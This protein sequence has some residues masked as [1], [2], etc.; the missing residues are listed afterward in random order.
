MMREDF[1]A[2]RRVLITGHTGFKGCWMA[3]R[4]KMLGADVHGLALAPDTS[5]ALFHQIGLTRE[6]CS[7]Q[8]DIRDLVALKK[9]VRDIRPDIVFHLA[10]QSLVRR[11]YAQ[12]I[13]TWATNVMGTAHVIQAVADLGSDCTIL[14]ITTDKV[15]ANREWVHPYRETDRLG[16][17]DP[18]SASKA[19]SEL[20]LESW[21]KSFLAGTGIRL[22]VARA[23]NVVGGGDWAEDRIVPDL[24]RALSRGVPI[25]VRNPA[26]TRPWQHVLDPLDG[27]LT[28]AE[29]LTSSDDPALRG[30]FNF[31][32]ESDSSRTVQTLVEEA[33]KHWPGR[34]K[35]I[36]TNDAPHEAGLLSL[37]TDKARHVLGWRPKWG[38]EQA[39]R[40]TVEWYRD[41]ERGAEPLKRCREQIAR[42]AEAA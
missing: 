7:R 38:F 25:P 36:Q 32:P 24:V 16:G 41:V 29:A 13:D 4:L 34:W 12:P 6:I 37:A 22:A 27:Y 23:G 17:H 28:L 10:A 8:L 11:S 19:A 15:Y 5:P 14:A 33:L 26:G 31:G 9:A 40:E 2:Q 1:W 20:L 21:R 39:I 3:L 42:Y 30:A 35:H 18:Y